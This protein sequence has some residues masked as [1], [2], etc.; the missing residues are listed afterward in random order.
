MKLTGFEKRVL[1]FC[2]LIILVF[3]YLLYDDSIFISK[4]VS[5]DK[6]IAELSLMKRD[7]RFKAS[8]SFSWLTARS[9][10][11]L[12]SNDSLF[13][14]DNSKAVI[15]LQDGSTLEIDS[16]SLIVLS[17]HKG[18]LV[19]DLK[20]G[21]LSGNLN[22]NA[23]LLLKTKEGFRNIR[24]QDGKAFRLERDFAVQSVQLARRL[25]A[26]D[27][28]IL[29]KNAKHFSINKSDTKTYQSFIWLTTGSI[30][31]TVIEISSTADFSAVDKLIKT[32]RTE[33]AVPV[34]LTEGSYF[35]RLKG[36]DYSRRHTATSTVHTFELVDKK[37][38]SLPSPILLTQNIRHSDSFNF[39]PVIK[40]GDVSSAEKYRVEISSSPRFEKVFH[41]ETAKAFFPWSDFR[42]GTYFVRLY[43]LSD[44]DT[45]LPSDIGTIE[46]R[47]Q[48]PQ[49]APISPIIVRTE[50]AAAVG[51]QKVSL[52]WTQ[53]K[54]LHGYRVEISKD[55]T[56]RDAEVVKTNR[57]PASVA[58]KQPGDYHVRVYAVDKDGRRLSPLSNVET[59][60]YQIKDLLSIP[61]LVR[62]YNETTVFMQQ[63]D[64]PYLWL[65]WKPVPEAEGFVVEIAHDEKFDRIIASEETNKNSY[66]VAKK[67]P[68][69]HYYWRVKSFSKTENAQSAWSSPNKF[70][71]LHKKREIFFE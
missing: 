56:F 38:N 13:T 31:E 7:V 41:Y 36:Y 54:T 19:I 16:Q 52:K 68:R 55:G 20:S 23:N 1:T 34:D 65:N 27:D 26:S 28:Q 46:I 30:Q 35:V 59:F 39:P 15:K 57:G 3:S 29:W 33:S 58:I 48:A 69:G 6:P 2:A 53:T 51:P 32:P 64:I 50:N 8:D 61:Q 71:L 43:S 37:A 62:P 44:G 11:Q 10:E 60:K 24:G 67:I 4:R 9:D 63:E 17:N 70:Y 49:L 40:W 22:P 5:K 18:Q 21:S 12:Y 42:A 14:G 47:T 66:M 45:S 25:P